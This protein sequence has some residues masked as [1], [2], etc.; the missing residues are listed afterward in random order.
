[1]TE[2]RRTRP[3]TEEDIPF[4]RAQLSVLQDRSKAAHMKHTDLDTAVEY[5]RSGIKGWRPPG[6]GPQAW[7]VDGFLVLATIGSPWHSSKPMVIE[8]MIMKVF[9]GGDVRYAVE[10]LSD[11]AKWHGIEVI[12]SGDTQIGYMTP[13]YE[14]DGF[15]KLGTQLI[16][17]I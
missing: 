13:F 7:L 1:M 6:S 10:F 11:I 2:D 14:G 16:K 12:V 5:I 17:E 9:P 3:V 8:D 4:I 15:R